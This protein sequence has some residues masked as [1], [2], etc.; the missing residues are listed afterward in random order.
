MESYWFAIYITMMTIVIQ[1]R[2]SA[3]QTQ[4]SRN[5]FLLLLLPNHTV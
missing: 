3:S 4:V 2:E 5:L 1:R